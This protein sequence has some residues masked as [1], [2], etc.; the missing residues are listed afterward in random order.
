MSVLETC[1]NGRMVGILKRFFIPGRL[2][3]CCI[4]VASHWLVVV[5]VVSILPAFT[6]SRS[7]DIAKPIIV[8]AGATWIAI[9]AAICWK[10]L[11]RRR[12]WIL[13]GSSVASVAFVV[14]WYCL[15]ADAIDSKLNVIPG[16][17]TG[18]ATGFDVG[19]FLDT[20][21][22]NLRFVILATF[23][24]WLLCY[25]LRKVL[26][27]IG[28]RLVWP[29]VL[30]GDR[31]MF[32]IGATVVMFAIAIWIRVVSAPGST[33]NLMTAGN[34]TASFGRLFVFF[35]YLVFVALVTL[36]WFPRSFV[37]QGMP[38]Q[39]VCSAILVCVL[40]SWGLIDSG[41][42]PPGEQPFVFFGGF[43]FVFSVFGLGRRISASEQEVLAVAN[44][45]RSWPSLFAIVPILFLVS[46]AA[47]QSY[48]DVGVAGLANGTSVG[49]F[50]NEA[51]ASVNVKWMSSGRISLELDPTMRQVIWRVRFDEDAPEDLLDVL[52]GR[53]ESR[54]IELSGLTPDFDVSTLENSRWTILLKDC[55]L[56]HSQLSSLLQSSSWFMIRGSFSVVDDGTVVDPGVATSIS[57]DRVDPGVIKDFFV[58]S[59]CEKQLSSVIVQSPVGNQDWPAIEEA[60]QSTFVYL[61][62]PFS[63]GFKIPTETR[64]LKQV[65][66]YAGRKL[67]PDYRN[68]LLNTD[69]KLWINLS[70]DNAALAW[71]LLLLRGDGSSFDLNTAWSQSGQALD[72]FAADI[73]LSYQLNDDQ[74]VHSVYLPGVNA[75]SVSSGLESVKVVSFDMGWV[76]AEVPV[77]SAGVATDISKLGELNSLEELYL[78]SNLIPENLSLLAN[79]KSLKHLQIAA[80]VR[81]VSGPVGFDACQSLESITIFGKPDN[82]SYREILRLE[83]LKRLVI[84]NHE[85]DASLD[86][87]YLEK[88]RK[89]FPGVDAD[90][91]LKSETESLVPL[92][93][94]K[95]RDRRRKELREDTSWLN[96]LHN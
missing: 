90:I 17:P 40:M 48:S 71:K 83:N 79:L 16:A 3:A 60:A 61:Y 27:A 86:A 34:S 24:I 75:G 55:E 54:L 31:T 92:S 70:P 96:E 39:K 26:R 11:S 89:R 12:T 80:V 18:S 78:D 33:T 95:F 28:S 30:R 22:S 94:R 76:G 8:V 45:V 25:L 64:S 87:T 59:K 19:R 91:V 13:I 49:Q 77:V 53:T 29:R 21:G 57:F 20:T 68:L 88:L 69:M 67:A 72:V 51:Q 32:L 81:R 46:L 23:F 82:Q 6:S 10:P 43:V 2:D 36:F 35:C 85:D 58:A 63:K 4:A 56:S 14:G 1:H 42:V 37:R 65:N 44:P 74:S 7:F 93:F 50:F 41:A 47:I 73:G 38:V 5:F 62:Q 66:Y 15:N 84:V 52:E 9:A